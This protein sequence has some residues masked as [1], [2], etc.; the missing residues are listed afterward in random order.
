MLLILFVLSGFF[1]FFVFFF[2]WAWW[3]AEVRV[4]KSWANI[5]SVKAIRL[6]SLWNNTKFCSLK[7]TACKLEW[8]KEIM[9]VCLLF[10]VNV[11]HLTKIIL[12]TGLINKRVQNSFNY[13]KS[14][15]LCFVPP[16]SLRSYFQP[17]AKKVSGTEVHI[18]LEYNLSKSCGELLA[19]QRQV[20]CGCIHR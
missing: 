10:F 11:F 15:S 16:D 14:D 8:K 2:Q 5:L 7:A 4:V 1:L 18:S 6:P 9:Y 12:E 19:P 13:P 3:T 17:S 20:P